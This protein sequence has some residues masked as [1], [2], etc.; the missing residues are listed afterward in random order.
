MNTFE[1]IDRIK[2]IGNN[3]SGYWQVI[4]EDCIITFAKID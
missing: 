3:I 2:S 4:S 1:K